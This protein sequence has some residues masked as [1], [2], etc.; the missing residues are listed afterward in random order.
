MEGLV[1]DNGDV[2]SDGE[3]VVIDAFDED[4]GVVVS[5]AEGFLAYEAY[6]LGRL[7]SWGF[8]THG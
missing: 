7:G 6:R 3:F 8:C 5:P 4:P 1:F 2:E